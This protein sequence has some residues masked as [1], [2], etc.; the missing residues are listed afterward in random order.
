MKLVS[1][2]KDSWKM[3]SMRI[4]FAITTLPLIW[5][6]IPEDLKPALAESQKVWIIVIL[7]LAGM[8]VR[9]IDQGF[10]TKK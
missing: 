10:E 2:W 7:G 1:N 8:V 9:N 4:F 5:A 3:W 6:S